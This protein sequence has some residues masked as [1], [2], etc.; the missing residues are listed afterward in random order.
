MNSP[1]PAAMDSPGPP[2]Y[3][4]ATMSAL[5]TDGFSSVVSPLTAPS[6]P[7]ARISVSPLAGTPITSRSTETLELSSV[8]T[9]RQRVPP[10]NYEC[11]P[12]VVDPDAPAAPATGLEVVH[13]P[14]QAVTRR[15]DE[16]TSGLEV[17]AVTQ[18]PQKVTPLHLLGDQPDSIDCPFCHRR[19][20]TRVKKK[21][22]NATHLQAVVLLFTTVCGVAAP[23]VAKWSF[24]IEQFCDSCNNRVAYRSQGKDLHIC[25]APVEWQETSKYPSANSNP[26]QG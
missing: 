12:E 8:Q 23:Y 10:V 24:D 19:T 6:S 2:S 13:L 7:V 15:E 20:D 1:N 9:S 4:E 5:T 3:S 14:P 22:S 16:Y 11:Y 25:K 18:T 17:M 21:P 26:T